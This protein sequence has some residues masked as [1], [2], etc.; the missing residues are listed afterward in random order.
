MLKSALGAFIKR[1]KIE[2]LY[3]EIVKNEKFNFLKSK[4]C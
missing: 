3:W 2:T 1:I 4:Y